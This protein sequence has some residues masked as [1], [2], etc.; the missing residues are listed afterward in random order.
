MNDVI[1]IRQNIG[2]EVLDTVCNTLWYVAR[3]E[4]GWE[5]WDEVQREIYLEIRMELSDE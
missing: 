5:I 1:G 2:F 4:F 3:Q